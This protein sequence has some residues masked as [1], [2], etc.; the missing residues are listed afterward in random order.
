VQ[1][2]ALFGRLDSPEPPFAPARAPGVNVDR[3]PLL[4]RRHTLKHG[5]CSSMSAPMSRR[6]VVVKLGSSTVVDARGRPRRERLR[7]VAADVAA[8]R[9]AGTPVCVV[10]S[11]AVALGLGALP[12]AQRRLDLPGLQAASAVG[13][14]LLVAAWQRAFGAADGL[15][16]GQVLLTAADVHARTAYLNAR[17]TLETLLRLGVV[18]VVNEND[19]TATDE[20]TFGDN[21]ALAAQVAALLR[22]RLLVLL[23]EVEG[24]YDREPSAGGATLI[25]EVRDHRLLDALDVDTASPTGLGSGGMRTKIVAAEMASTSGVACVI[26]SGAAPGALRRA[27]AGEAVGTRFPA[28][29]R[30]ISAFKLW[31]RYGKPAAGRVVVDA[32]ARRALE[33]GG[34]SLLPVGVTAVDGAFAAGDSVRICGPDG[35]EFATGLASLDAAEIRRLAG[36]REV[37]EAV[38]RDYLVVHGS[39]GLA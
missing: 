20:L 38:H 32:G 26:A 22:A 1:A 35:V 25:R 28:D 14:G 27:A 18:P 5:Q 11:G 36:R 10:S 39:R 29:P 13:Q 9:E 31:L 8:L 3:C 21:D 6:A 34:A 2:V 12:H 17:A 24:L 30:R 33:T 16:V 23:T 19:S 4:T 37:E 7:A 15:R